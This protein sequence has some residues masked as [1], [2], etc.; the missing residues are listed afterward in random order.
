MHHSEENSILKAPAYPL[1][2]P[3][4]FNRLRAALTEAFGRE[5][6]FPRLGKLVDHP[7]STVQHWFHTF[8]HPHV[9]FFLCLLEQLPERKRAELIGEFCRE[10]PLLSHARI[11]HDPLAVSA[12]ENIL[13][14]HQACT[15]IRG[16]SAFQRTFVA[17]ALCHSAVRNFGQ[18]SMVA[19]LDAH[20]PRKFVPAHGIS[21]CRQPMNSSELQGIIS[22]TWP[23]ISV[24]TA[25]FILFNGIWPAAGNLRGSI[26]KLASNHHLI[27]ADPT[28]PDAPD[29]K[30]ITKAKTHV[31]TVSTARENSAWIRIAVTVL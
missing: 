7:R 27:L 10:L 2:G 28:L 29:I 24:S 12:L 30:C 15:V 17:T 20:E 23:E 11:S 13:Q 21:Y 5:Q 1:A 18:N 25:R 8:H 16:G 22:A 4:V 26:L 19:G 3:K 14:D 9:I 6:D 31:I